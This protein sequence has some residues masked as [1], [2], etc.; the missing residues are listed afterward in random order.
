MPSGKIKMFN[1]EKGFG[2]IKPNDGGVDVFFHIGD[3]HIDQIVVQTAATDAK[4]IA[5]DIGGA[6]RRN[7]SANITTQANT[8]LN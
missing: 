7:L 6:V 4:G 2:F 5:R 8:G 1:E 3:V